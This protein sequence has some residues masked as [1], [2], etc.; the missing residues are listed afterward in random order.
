MES[1]AQAAH[2]GGVQMTLDAD[3]FRDVITP[4]ID[5]CQA[6]DGDMSVG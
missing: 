6:E 4:V 2:D 5:A 3:G 1:A